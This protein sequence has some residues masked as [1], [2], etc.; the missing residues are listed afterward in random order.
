MRIVNRIL[1]FLAVAWLMIFSLPLAA[2]ELRPAYLQVTEIG[3]GAYDL[4]WK[5]PAAGEN[6][7]LSLAP[8]FDGKA[9]RIGEPVDAF[10][11]GAHVSRWKVECPDGIAGTQLTIDGLSNTFT[12]ALVRVAYADGTEFVTRLQ[13]DN[14]SVVITAAP[15]PA[16]VAWTYTVLGVEHILL[17]IDHLLFVLALVLLVKGWRRLLA[18]ITAFTVS[19]SITLAAATLGYVHVPGPPVEACIALSIVF[20]A[21]EIIRAH[22]NGPGLAERAPWLVAFSFGLLHGLGF[23]GALSAVGLPPQAIPVA[24]LFFN[25]GVELGQLAFVAV[26]LVVM[27]AGRKLPIRVPQWSWR[28]APYSIGGMAMFW[29]IQRIDAF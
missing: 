17:G 4:V 12:D 18:T 7:R 6:M 9:K 24:L 26:V 1:R 19:H 20:V 8:R 25:I 15:G 27:A 13:P 23:A 5:V 21:A 29:M 3:G 11:G 22:R 16:A 2:H 10:T 14:P 28:I